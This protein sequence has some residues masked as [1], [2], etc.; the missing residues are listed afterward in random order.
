MSRTDARPQLS[1]LDR[2]LDDAPKIREEVPLA[3]SKAAQRL[4]QAVRRD[5]EWL[6]NT[7]RDN[8][9]LGDEFEQLKSSIYAYGLP[10]FSSFGMGAKQ[11]ESRVRLA[12][13]QV[14]QTF[15]P[16]LMH[17]TVTPT[18]TDKDEKKR[19]LN[20]RITALLRVDPEPE[21]VSYE[22]VLEVSRGEFRIHKD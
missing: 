8:A 10:D 5:L 18:G 17:V 2:L 20:F 11:A 14:L 16:R 6:L 21:P 7:R 22:T 9:E 12:L 3:P 15:E 13:Q 4:R 1:V 19:V